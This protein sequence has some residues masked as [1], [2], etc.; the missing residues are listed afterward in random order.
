MLRPEI[1]HA[2]LTLD[3]RTLDEAAVLGARSFFDDPFFVHLSGEPRLRVR[4]LTLYIRSH[5]AVLRDAAVSTGAR[6]TAGT[7]VGICVWQRPGTYP[8]SG[9]R[10]AREMAGALRAL[11]PRPPSLLTGIRYVRA[12]ERAHPRHEHWYLALLAV[13]PMVWRRGIGTSLLEPS[14]TWI[15]QEGLPCY[16]ETQ[17]EANLAYYRRFGFDETERLTPSVGGPPLF[18]MTRPPR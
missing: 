14:L 3:R 12:M 4:G 11:I 18:T 2:R 13:D 15:D 17:K 8:L 16:L 6:D 10:Q 5:L 7:L 9:G 1:T